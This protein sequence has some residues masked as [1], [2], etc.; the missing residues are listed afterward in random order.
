MKKILFLMPLMAISF[1]T[2]CGNNNPPDPPEP[3]PEGIGDALKFTCNS[4]NGSLNIYSGSYEPED[5][6]SN[7]STNIKYVVKDAS[8]QE[9]DRGELIIDGA[10]EQH[11]YTLCN[12]LKKGDSVYLY[13]NNPSGFNK[14]EIAIDEEGKPIL[15]NITDI[16]FYTGD[17]DNFSVSGNIMSLIKETDFDQLKKAPGLGCFNLLFA[18]DIDEEPVNDEKKYHCNITDA[19]ELCIPC[20][21]D[22]SHATL[23]ANC[24]T[25]EKAPKLPAMDLELGCYSGMF[26]GCEKL[27]VA[28]EL[29]AFTLAY[30][31]YSD[32]FRGC[33]SLKS[34]PELQAATLADSC[35]M[36][37]FAH[38]ENLKT[39]PSIIKADEFKPGCC[40]Q[41]FFECNNLKTA[42]MTIEAS[43]LAE[44]CCEEMF[45]GCDSLVTAPNLPS[46]ELA[47]CCYYGMFLECAA[48][49]KVFELP[50][51]T[52]RESCYSRMF[53]QCEALT[54]A[55]IIKAKTLEESSCSYMFAHCTQLT[56]KAASS[57]GYPFFTCPSGKTE[58]TYDMFFDTIGDFASGDK[59][60]P[61]QVCYCEQPA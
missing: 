34:A 36:R 55:P 38:C 58:A 4:D 59:L 20:T 54:Q 8:D 23:F 17:N 5:P 50:A 46:T 12:D 13:G 57:G 26:V 45:Y 25:L 32:M 35:Y 49:T 53:Y 16:T 9:K 21:G 33:T 19:S 22:L 51:T 56:I 11:E 29:P 47:N 18:S 40:F 14:I 1:L 27:V 15:K 48:L 37:M 7:V 42:P 28:P 60:N 6:T 10:K 39:A 43:K 2:N 30:G 3:E 24:K 52:L 41:M 44:N 31:C 61:G